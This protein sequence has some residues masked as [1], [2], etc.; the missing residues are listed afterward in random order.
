[1]G[2]RGPKPT[3]VESRFHSKVQRS[4]GCWEWTGSKTQGYGQ[5]GMPG[6]KPLRAHRLSYEFTYGPIPIG[7][8]VLHRCDNRGCVRPDHL[9]LGTR[10]DN[11]RDMARKGRSGGQKITDD[12]AYAIL[13]REASG[14]A[15]KDL[16]VEYNLHFAT[17]C[18]IVNRRMYR[19]LSEPW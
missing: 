5:L 7:M 6:A 19:H 15:I 10:P 12:Q 13:W 14:E 16:A 1:M 3:S 18:K 8:C 2:K 4:D 17:I 9:F 11:S